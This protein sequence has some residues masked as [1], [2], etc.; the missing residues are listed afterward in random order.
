MRIHII[1]EYCTAYGTQLSSSITKLNAEN[2][3][4]EYHTDSG[5][6]SKWCG[7]GG[8]RLG[9]MVFPPQLRWLREAMA[10]V[11]GETF[12]A[13]AAP[14]QYAAVTAFNGGA[15]I[16][17]YLFQSRRIIRA[18]G[19]W[20]G[21]RLRDAGLAVDMP[22]G[23][24]YLFPDFTPRAESLRARGIS[25]SSELCE[26]L[27]TE[28]GVALLP[29]SDFG[30]PPELLAARLAYVDFDGAEALLAAECVP[31]EVELGEPWLHTNCSRVVAA[32]EALISW[33]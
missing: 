4:D 23:G 9:T 18:T 19:R 15:E 5:G 16:E 8:W 24:F 14:I 27:L 7:A 20:T 32:I 26:R 33:L 2:I 13:V 31:D 21:Q 29:G 30:C 11:A 1:A 17:R 10:V 25:N 22:Q 6:L 3:A 28:T 12:S